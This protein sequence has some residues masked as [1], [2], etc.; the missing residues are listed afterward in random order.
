MFGMICRPA[1]SKERGY[2]IRMEDGQLHKA[3]AVFVDVCGDH[4]A[5]KD[6]EGSLVFMARLDR[7][8]TVRR[9]TLKEPV[10]EC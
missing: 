5:L 8:R 3:A 2:E 4:I 9:E 7:V 6:A 10:R 1:P